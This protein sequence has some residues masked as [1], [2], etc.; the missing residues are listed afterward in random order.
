MIHMLNKTK[1]TALI[2]ANKKD[3]TRCHLDYSAKRKAIMLSGHVIYDVSVAPAIGVIKSE[4][5]DVH[6]SFAI[7]GGNVI[8]SMDSVFEQFDAT[9]LKCS[10]ALTPYRMDV[11][12]FKQGLRVFV[13]DNGEQV[14][15]NQ[16]YLDVLDDSILNSIEF[17]T[18]ER[19]A[20]PIL[21]IK[22]G[23]RVCYILPVRQYADSRYGVIDTTKGAIK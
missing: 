21:G 8:D 22:D 6:R 7:R 10:L 13:R 14:Y 18:G 15:C 1:L 2:K 23:I 16:D 5:L 17:Y 12:G 9:D 4:L 3:G 19:F 11:K 20:S